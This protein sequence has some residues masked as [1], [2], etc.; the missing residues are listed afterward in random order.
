MYHTCY[1]IIN[2]HVLVTIENQLSWCHI[3]LWY[4]IPIMHACHMHVTS[5]HTCDMHVT[6]ILHQYIHVTCMLHACIHHGCHHYYN[7][8]DMHAT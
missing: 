7:M 4:F 8:Y 5:I 3:S 2:V 1:M 6:C